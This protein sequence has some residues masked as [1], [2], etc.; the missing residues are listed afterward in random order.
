MKDLYLRRLLCCPLV[1]LEICLK[2]SYFLSIYL[3]CHF[4][5]SISWSQFFC[6]SV[7]KEKEQMSNVR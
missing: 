3:V 4:G 1:L 5:K 6:K 2:I 7:V